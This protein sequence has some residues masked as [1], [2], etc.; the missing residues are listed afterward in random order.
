VFVEGF[1]GKSLVA[2]HKQVKSRMV[3]D[4]SSE[5]KVGEITYTFKLCSSFGVA[6]SITNDAP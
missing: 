3:I 5:L 6:Y 4:F 1:T 2:L